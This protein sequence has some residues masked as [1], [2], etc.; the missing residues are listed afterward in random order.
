MDPKYHFPSRQWSIFYVY[1]IRVTRGGDEQRPLSL[2]FPT[3]VSRQMSIPRVTCSN[4][5]F[6]KYWTYSEGKT[7]G[8]HL[9]RWIFTSVE[10][11]ECLSILDPNF[12]H[13]GSRSR[14]E[15]F[16]Y[17]IAKKWFLSSRKYD[18][19]CSL[20]IPD[21]NPDFY[22]SRFPIQGSKSHRSRIPDPQ[23]C[24]S[25]GLIKRRGKCGPFIYT[26]LYVF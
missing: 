5:P 9:N 14:I 26:R 25:P 2:T 18:P 20:F 11:Q 12:F 7:K 17:F 6:H 3:P 19:G 21:P 10:D 24:F 23:H 13:P 22:P 16:M 1:L 4:L 8:D 15:E